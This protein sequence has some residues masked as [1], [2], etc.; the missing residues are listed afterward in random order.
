MQDSQENTPGAALDL[1]PS[2]AAEQ[3][4][5]QSWLVWLAKVRILILTFLLGIELAVT[6]LTAS[7]INRRQFVVVIGFCYAVS[8][9]LAYVAS[10]WRNS[11]THTWL[12]I[13]TD[14]GMAT[15]LVYA[16]GAFDSPFLLSVSIDHHQRQYSSEPPLVDDDCCTGL[17]PACGNA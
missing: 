16:T 10:Q 1:Q 15:M 9:L 8:A 12:Q 2:A 14:L 13:L 4:Y 7:P 17:H 11:L 3:A 6:N 5:E